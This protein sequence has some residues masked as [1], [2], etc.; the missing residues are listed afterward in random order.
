M[1]EGLVL[2]LCSH[3]PFIHPFA[4]V[5]PFFSAYPINGRRVARAYPSLL[6]THASKM[7]HY[8]LKYMKLQF[9]KRIKVTSDSLTVCMSIMSVPRTERLHTKCF[10]K[11]FSH[12]FCFHFCIFKQ[13]IYLCIAFLWYTFQQGLILYYFLISWGLHYKS[14][15]WY[16]FFLSRAV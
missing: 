16:I 5:H 8:K 1:N 2:I 15:L 14:L 3:Y 4:S 6:T 10:F 13:F 11:E 7:S 9:R 12:K